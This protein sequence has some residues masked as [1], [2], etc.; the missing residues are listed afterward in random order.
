MQGRT[1][2]GCETRGRNPEGCQTVAGG[3][4]A[5]E[6]SGVRTKMDCTQKGCQKWIDGDRSMSP[7]V[8]RELRIIRNG[9]TMLVW[10]PFWVPGAWA[11]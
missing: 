6:T 8:N 11:R 7:A 10:H 3:R 9:S 1:I 4:N 2:E 5:V